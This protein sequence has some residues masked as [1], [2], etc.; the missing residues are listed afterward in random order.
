MGFEVEVDVSG[1]EVCAY[2]ILCDDASLLIGEDGR[3]VRALEFLFKK[4]LDQSLRTE[5]FVVDVD[6]YR[7][8]RLG[9]LKE[10]ARSSA[11]RVRLQGKEVALDPLPSY[12]R[13]AVHI[14]LQEYPDIVTESVGEEPNRR[15]VIRP[16]P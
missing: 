4:V 13:R 5:P 12:E 1:G 15:V 9:A 6:S 11:Q 7:K 3:N 14:A 8:R 2:N 10:E 16:Y